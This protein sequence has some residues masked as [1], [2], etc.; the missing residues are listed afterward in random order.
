M[1]CMKPVE[2]KNGTL[3]N[4][5]G[6]VCSKVLRSGINLSLIDR[7]HCDVLY[8]AIIVTHG[9]GSKW[10]LRVVQAGEQVG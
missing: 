1:K 6:Q 8:Y 2:R 9:P 3:L 5:K 7:E 4:C 10:T